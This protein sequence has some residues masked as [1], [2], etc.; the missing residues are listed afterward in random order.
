MDILFKEFKGSFISS[1]PDV[2]IMLI[3]STLFIFL[4]EQEKTVSITIRIIAK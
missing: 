2:K 3:G 1:S 4:A